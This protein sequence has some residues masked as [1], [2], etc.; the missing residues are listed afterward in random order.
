[1]VSYSRNTPA[2]RTAPAAAAVVVVAAFL[3]GAGA[4]G[5][6]SVL[7]S[8]WLRVLLAVVLVVAGW[9][10]TRAGRYPDDPLPLALG[11]RLVLGVGTS[12]AVLGAYLLG[13][14]LLT[15]AVPSSPV[16]VVLLVYGVP[17]VAL[18]AAVSTGT[19]AWAAG[20]GA[21]LPMLAV[22]LLVTAEVDAGTV[23]VT[24]LVVAVLLVAIVVRAPAASPWSRVASAASAMAASFAFGSGASPFGSLGTTQLGGAAGDG[25]SGG[26]TGGA[27]AVVVAGALAVAVVVLVL[28]VPR[29]DLAA[30][31]L[32]A[33]LFTVPP[34]LLL[35]DPMSEW[36]TATQ[37]ALVAV[38]TATALVA[39]AA[40][41]SYRFRRAL[42]A[43][44]RAA[45][46]QRPGQDP[47]DTAHPATDAGPADTVRSATDADPADAARPPTTTDVGH[48]PPIPSDA[49]SAAA[50]AV[51][52]A[53]AAV[54]FVVVALPVFGWE[55]RLQGVVTL[56]VLVG[57]SALAY[58]LPRGTPGAAAAVV[59]LLGLALTSPW[60][61]LLTGGRIELNT[62]DRVLT[63][64]VDLVVA[65][66]LAW[67]LVRRHPRP[68]VYAAAAYVLAASAAAC[69]GS[70]LFDPGHFPSEWA[71][72]AVLTL[73]LLLLAIPAA[74]VAFG[75]HAAIG[76]AVGAV[77]I[78]A[79][80]FLPMKVMV[81]EFGGGAH[82]YALQLSL[83]PLTPTDWLMT[84]TALRDV[85]G[86]ALVAVIATVLVA[87]VLVASL[88]RR[89]SAPLAAAVALLL[90]SAVQASMLTALAEW[91]ADEAEVLGWA[92]G[93]GALV[94][95][96][97]A[98]A[99]ARTATRP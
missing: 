92:L 96:L 49:A 61:R 17:A 54:A 4:V 3:V 71:L 45:P 94:A 81:G 80:G 13:L 87:F 40:I 64:V 97:T 46:T 15:A 14:A 9:A 34:V 5:A 21:I 8:A 37:V 56:L 99:A 22:L 20:A 28:A 79:A 55:A 16:A 88:A 47:S 30:G 82:G 12:F 69:L 72:V 95:A 73:P 52:V 67:L 31:V 25:A 26:L 53:A 66:V 41:R 32:A 65:G 1:M 18:L 50:C 19:R 43:T 98:V 86:P 75:P 68:G 39:L 11:H 2:T 48:P 76:Q 38:P 70:L 85:T 60:I 84:S 78:A 6:S 57:A 10:V 33:S 58:W 77:A 24:M 27:Q 63:G 42:A 93:A 23:S 36:S 62:T 90:L 51:V 74:V 83:S 35:T 29:R 91:S 89:P 7:T 59:A 44:V